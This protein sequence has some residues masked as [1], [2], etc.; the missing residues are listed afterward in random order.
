[1]RIVARPSVRVLSNESGV[2][3][4]SWIMR[5]SIWSVVHANKCWVLSESKLVEFQLI[6]WNMVFG[7]PSPG[8]PMVGSTPC[9]SLRGHTTMADLQVMCHH[10]LMSWL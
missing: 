10:V 7:G 3:P 4:N 5:Q 6:M 1:M 8:K 2:L 9:V